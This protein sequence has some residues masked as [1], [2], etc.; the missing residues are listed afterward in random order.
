MKQENQ[1]DGHI[2]QEFFEKTGG[3]CRTTNIMTSRLLA[4]TAALTLITIGAHAQQVPGATFAA[5]AWGP[6][7]LDVFGQGQNQH[8]YHASYDG[9]WS[10]WEDLG[11]VFP[12]GA[13]FAAVAW[14]PG[15]LDVFGQ[16][17]TGRVLVELEPTDWP[18][19]HGL[20][21]GVL[22]C[23]VAKT[24]VSDD[25]KIGEIAAVRNRG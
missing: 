18:W 6:G 22:V 8:A 20:P 12:V 9:G 13:T 17:L 14:G 3:V 23:A 11:G 15:R 7:R 4:L 16:G 10:G 21:V 1:N 19:F 2:T 24:G 5:V 25:I